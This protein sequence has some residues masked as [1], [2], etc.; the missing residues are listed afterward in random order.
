MGVCGHGLGLGTAL[1]WENVQP[2]TCD[3]AAGPTSSARQRLVSAECPDHPHRVRLNRTALGLNATEPFPPRPCWFVGT[4]WGCRVMPRDG[5]RRTGVDLGSIILLMVT[6]V[7][8]VVPVAFV[9]CVS[10][11]DRVPDPPY[12]RSVHSETGGLAAL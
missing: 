4:M 6:V 7:V 10:G 11:G 9:V 3:V 5:P 1:R 8:A 12:G 2:G